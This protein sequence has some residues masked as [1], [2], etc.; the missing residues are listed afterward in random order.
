MKPVIGLLLVGAV[1]SGC[2][3]A[4]AQSTPNVAVYPA[5]GQTP[6]QQAKDSAECST[7]AKENSGYNPA[8]D[9]AKGVGVGAAIGA[10]GGAAIG[11]ATGAITGSPGRGAAVGAVA[12]GIGGGVVGGAQQYGKSEDGYKKAFAACMSGRDY[13]VAR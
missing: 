8:G 1:L 11:A 5:K 10:L 9:T 13:S 12:G 7:W 2:A 4:G 3:S 6:E